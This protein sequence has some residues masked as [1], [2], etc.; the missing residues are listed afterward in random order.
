MA[1][2]ALSKALNHYKTERIGTED[3]LIKCIKKVNLDKPILFREKK[4]VLW[5]EST[6]NK[7][8]D[9]LNQANLEEAL[10]K[11]KQ[12]RHEENTK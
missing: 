3:D 7:D 9:N 2:D 10:R 6:G 5:K 8:E 4:S 11:G 12:V 1:V